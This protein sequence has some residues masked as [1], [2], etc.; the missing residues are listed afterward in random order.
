M[1][2]DVKFLIP[3]AGVMVRDPR[4]KEPLPEKGDYKDW[5]G[6]SGN[7]WRRRSRDG[8]IMVYDE[9]QEELKFEKSNFDKKGEVKND[10]F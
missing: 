6:P 5:T 3:K 9:K 8:D 1:S 7:Y 2:A 10:K 4:S